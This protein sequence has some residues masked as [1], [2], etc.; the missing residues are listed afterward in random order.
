MKYV[1]ITPAHNEERF[2]T[3]TL[4]SMAAQTLLPERWIIVNDGSTDKTAD[5]A[6]KY[7]QRFPWIQLVHR[8]PRL[9][10]HFGA[11]VHAFNGGLERVGSI[12]F[13]VIGNL[14]ADISFDPEYLS[15]LMRK[16][17]EDPKL[18]VAGTPFTEDGGY[19][20]A[21]DSFEGENHVAG[22][23]QLFRR[24]CFEDVGG[25]IPNPAGGVDWIA[26][27]TARMKGWKTRSFPEKRFHHYRT[28][29][30]AGRSR[31]AASFS[32]GEKDYYLGGSPL[33]QLFRVAYR[34]TKQPLDGAALLAGYCWAA[35]RRMK[36]PV[37]RELMR[38]HRRE[39][40]RKLRNIFS[41]LLKFR[42]INNFYAEK[43][44]QEAP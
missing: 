17:S 7:A 42:K 18:G 16:F 12:D 1:L 29:G 10:R 24:R 11:K 32:Y 34:A 25:Y 33:W 6:A 19:D 21:R 38:F 2:I 31:A 41:S 40:T 43:G 4:E 39:Q 37:C 15:F 9:D 35:A 23:C 8:S 28:L 26:V 5:I 14:D 36:R 20:T 44:Q 22:G 30:T 27:T 13:D 3:K